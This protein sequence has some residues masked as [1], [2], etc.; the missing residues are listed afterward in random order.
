VQLTESNVISAAQHAH[1]QGRSGEALQQ[2]RPLLAHQPSIAV[3]TLAAQTAAACGELRVAFDALR[4]LASREPD[5]TSHL[6]SMVELA[7][8]KPLDVP[9]KRSDV[10]SIDVVVC[11]TDAA[12]LDRFRSSVNTTWGA[13]AARVIHV[14]DARSL[15]DGYTRGLAQATS[16][17]VVLCHDDIRFIAPPHASWPALIREHLREWDLI[18]VAGTDKLATPGVMGSGPHH[19]HGWIAH[20]NQ[21]TGILVGM[22]SSQTRPI[23]AQALD[24][25]LL[26]A[27]RELF[28]RIAFDEQTFDGFH[29]YDLDIS[30]RAHRSGFGVAVCPDLWLIHESMGIFSQQW[31]GYADRIRAK[32]PELSGDRKPPWYFSE[33]V[34]DEA[35]ARA[36]YNRLWWALADAR[37]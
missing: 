4:S 30:Y 17:V 1:L 8:W 16:D 18:G 19:A 32:F 37:E 9:A 13:G 11:S 7:C 33:V 25:V 6:Q 14:A 12:K 34:P 24:G 15:A 23:A 26:A 5:N 3:L 20:A 21:P 22:L 2:L 29:G 10:A 31:Q 35:H 36:A 27:R 28:S